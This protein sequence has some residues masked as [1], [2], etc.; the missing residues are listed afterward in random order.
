VTA[1]VAAGADLFLP[2]SRW[3]LKLAYDAHYG[4]RVRDQGVSLKATIRF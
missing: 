1:D 3:A 2:D 4:A